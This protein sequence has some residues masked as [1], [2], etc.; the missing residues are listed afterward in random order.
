MKLIKLKPTTSGTRH[1]L[2]IQKSLLS[3][4]NKLGK[5]SICG[6]KQFS[7]RSVVNG[8]ITVWHKGGACKSNF[9]KINFF[10]TEFE[11]I[12]VCVMYDP[13]RSAFISLNFDLH[14]Q[15]FFRTLATHFVYTGS[16][17]SCT[18]QQKELS[19]GNRTVVKNIPTG[20]L[21]HSLTNSYNNNKTCYARSAGTFCQ[22]LQKGIQ[23]H[24]VRLPSG[25][26]IT[27]VDNAYAT[28]GVVS[29]LQQNSVI[30]GKAGKNRLK[31][32]RPSVRGIAMNPV[33]HP[34]G[35]RTNGGRPS[36]TPWGIP[37]K[38]KPSVK[39]KIYV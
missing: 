29:N 10:N 1:Q 30:I 33:D 24:K 20:S 14:K 26:I 4:T 15:I 31:G 25:N 34:H 8:R 9:R 23:R 39:K 38:G 28:L 27:V 12:V 18:D 36:V 2:K 19:L 16:L 21:V 35:G 6:L 37:T 3:K 7:G 22:L 5:N 17:I 13:S 32:I 11:S